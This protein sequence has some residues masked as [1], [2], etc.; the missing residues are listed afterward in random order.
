LSFPILLVKAK[1][2]PC[3][4]FINGAVWGYKSMREALAEEAKK[5][6][7]PTEFE[8]FDEPWQSSL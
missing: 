2:D 3:A 8:L 6:S 7:L 5:R 4:G 1:K